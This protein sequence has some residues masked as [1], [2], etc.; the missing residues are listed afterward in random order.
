MHAHHP[1]GIIGPMDFLDLD[2]DGTLLVLTV[3]VL[4]LTLTLAFAVLSLQ[5]VLKPLLQALA[6]LLTAAP[7]TATVE[8]ESLE[9]EA[10]GIGTRCCQAPLPEAREPQLVPAV[11]RVSTE[12]LAESTRRRVAR[13]RSDPE[14]VTR[15]ADSH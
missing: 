11:V 5:R 3:A 12:E 13:D 15:I 2:T 8:L 1:T 10:C 6:Q 7:A 4:I 14:P 9:V